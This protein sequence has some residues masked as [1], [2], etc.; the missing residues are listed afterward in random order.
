MITIAESNDQVEWN[1]LTHKTMYT[2]PVLSY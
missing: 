2:Q 1:E